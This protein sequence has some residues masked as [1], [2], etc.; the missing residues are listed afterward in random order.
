[1][2]DTAEYQVKVEEALK[3]VE[4]VKHGVL[5]LSEPMKSQGKDLCEIAYDF[6]K[7]TAGD[8]TE[9]M[10]RNLGPNI[11]SMNPKQQMAVFALSCRGYEGLDEK[12]LERLSA[13]DAMAG[14][15]IGGQYLE[16][17][18]SVALVSRMIAWKEGE[19]P[20]SYYRKGTMRL[21]KEIEIDGE[22]HTR[23]PYD[24]GRMTG[25]KYVEVLSATS[26]TKAGFSYR[27]ALKLYLEAVRTANKWDDQ[28]MK[29]LAGK[30]TPEDI[31]SGQRVAIGFFLTAFLGARNRMSRK[32]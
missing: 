4:E 12:D 10:D 15:M 20:D 32:R 16:H 28:I 24:F 19:N 8:M 18:E 29:G 2:Q 26:G 7:I 13:E 27:Q 14:V 25:T 22:A 17:L 11:G 1:M 5:T 3:R 9:A 23:I 6:T 30:L 31:F 21:E